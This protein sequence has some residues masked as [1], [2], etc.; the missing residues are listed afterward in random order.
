MKSKYEKD[1]VSE[2]IQDIQ[3]ERG[4]PN[5]ESLLNSGMTKSRLQYKSAAN[6]LSEDE[7]EEAQQAGFDKAEEIRDEEA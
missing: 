4:Y 6:E 7:L 5:L 3:E 1:L 2:I